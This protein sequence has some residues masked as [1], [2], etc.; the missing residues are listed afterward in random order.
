[1]GVLD[2]HCE[3]L[4]RDP[5]EITRTRLGTLAIAGTHEEAEQ[6]LARGPTG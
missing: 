3:D 6:Q 2:A 5:A 1:M 4:G